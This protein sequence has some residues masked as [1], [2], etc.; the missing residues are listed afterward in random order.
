MVGTAVASKIMRYSS[1][2][3]SEDVREQQPKT[4]VWRRSTVVLAATSGLAA[5]G[6]VLFMAK[7][8]SVENGEA[9]SLRALARPFQMYQ[10]DLPMPNS[11]TQ[12]DGAE[13]NRYMQVI[14]NKWNEA[15]VFAVGDWGAPLKTGHVTAGSQAGVDDH[16][17]YS[18][19]NAMKSRAAWANP[20]YILNVGDNFYYG[21]I[22]MDCNMPPNAAWGQAKA[23]FSSGWQGIYGELA[24]KPWLSTLGN[25]DYGGWQF[26]MGWPQQIGYSFMN[27]NWIMPARYYM[28]RIEH[29][30]FVA[31]Y[32]MI[33]SNAYDAKDFNDP[34]TSHNICSPHNTGGVGTCANNGGMASI[35]ACKD[36]FWG[37]YAKQ[38]QWLENKLAAS[39]A[40]WKVVVTHFPCGYDGPFY[41]DMKTKH[42]LD[43][44]VTGHRHQQELWKPDS[45][46]KYVQS[47]MKA[48]LW[49]GAAPAC[50]VTGGGG[51][52]VSEA[53]G[54]ADYGEDLLTYGF[55][56][57]TMNKAWLKIEL[58]K[59]DNTV[60]GNWTI[61][62]HGTKKAE[63]QAKA[64]LR[65]DI[66]LCAD[67]CGD[68]NNP[69]GKVCPGGSAPFA[70][71]AGCKGCSNMAKD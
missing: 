50:F 53:F 7:R 34:A 19:A 59:P 63:E 49:D 41:R 9:T 16:A 35:D 8:R 58:V 68:M 65:D 43:L 62:P 15:H 69:W 23:D 4:R 17:Q 3:P 1:L 20:Q 42:G 67:F 24:N 56:H 2:T 36:W 40:D 28:K 57:L 25:H 11:A 30:D 6:T 13:D 70:S 37:S 64:T 31:D 38:K 47:M 5:C 51:G 33:D 54:Y 60:H 21:G 61:Y 14:H 66:G 48:S 52:I 27:Y 26:N 71:C 22:E 12:Y 46:S 29:P 39:D 55:F 45:N 18:V 44:L 10:G 32:F